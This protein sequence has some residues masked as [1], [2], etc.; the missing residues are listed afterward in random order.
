[1][2]FCT[3]KHNQCESIDYNET[4]YGLTNDKEQRF[5]HCNCDMEFYDCL[6]RLNSTMSSYVG[7][8]YFNANYRCYRFDLEID[9]CNEYDNHKIYASQERC[10]RYLLFVN[11]PRKMQWFDL[12]FYGG[13]T[14]QNSLLVIKPP[15][16]DE[17]D[18]AETKESE[19]LAEFN[20]TNELN[21]DENYL[22]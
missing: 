7:E 2:E 10:V 19:E 22:K 4:K 1:M 9:A 20:E 11:M 13:K 15:Y 5:W 12:P 3:R 6:H 17:L 21:S 8:L 16:T 18:P 14:I